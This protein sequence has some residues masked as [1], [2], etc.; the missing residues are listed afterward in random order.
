M[1][2]DSSANVKASKIMLVGLDH[3][4]ILEKRF[5]T[6]GYQVVTKNDMQ[7]RSNMYGTN[8]WKPPCWCRVDR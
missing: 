2:P 3:N 4:Q 5:K 7:Q 8:H 1:S 6:A